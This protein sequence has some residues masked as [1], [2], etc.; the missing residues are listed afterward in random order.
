MECSDDAKMQHRY[1]TTKCCKGP[2]QCKINPVLAKQKNDSVR[3]SEAKCEN[4]FSFRMA[5]A[6]MR[7]SPAFPH[8]HGLEIFQF[9]VW[10]WRKCHIQH[11]NAGLKKVHQADRHRERQRPEATFTQ[12]GREKSS[13]W[14]T[15]SACSCPR[16][17]SGESCSR[18]F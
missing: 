9:W 4:R 12:H 6:F 11:R 14:R 17:P 15:W 10:I 16:R 1:A 2:K 13:F 8:A 18:Q 3:S 5:A 7:S